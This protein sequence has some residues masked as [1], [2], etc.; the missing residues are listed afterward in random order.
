MLDSRELDQLRFRHGASSKSDSSN[1][2]HQHSSLCLRIHLDVEP[3]LQIAFWLETRSSAPHCA[4]KKKT[5]G[6]CESPLKVVCVNMSDLLVC[7]DPSHLGPY[8]LACVISTRQVSELFDSDDTHADLKYTRAHTH[9]QCRLSAH[10]AERETW[11]RKVSRDLSY[12]IPSLHLSLS[13]LFSLIIH[14]H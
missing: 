3:I 14:S 11:Q 10:P 2:Y 4:V 6:I 7:D 8:S 5:H 12:L 1:A 9:T 13:F